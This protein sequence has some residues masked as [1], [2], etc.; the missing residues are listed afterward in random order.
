[1]NGVSTV[2][3][4]FPGNFAWGF[5]VGL[6]M[7]NL[8]LSTLQSLGFAILVYSGSAQMVAMPLMAQSTAISFVCLAAFLGCIRFIIYSAA[9]APNLNHLPLPLRLFVSA[10]SID[11][12]IGLYLARRANEQE[13][14]G[15]FAHRIAFLVGM[16]S[17]VWTAW[18]SGMVT[19]IFAAA[20]LPA[21][22][23]FSYLGIVA[24]IGIVVVMVQNRAGWACVLASA[25]VSLLTLHWPHQLGL[26][27][28]I[29]VGMAIGFGLNR[30][31]EVKDTNTRRTT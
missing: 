2:V 23:K 14:K 7:V 27:M 11:S 1:L 12:A 8:G 13:S 22:E 3:A 21:S 19:G 4:T 6:S 18:M 9:M 30:L 17:L 26:F 10:F 20:A 16:N 29:V 31:P 28:S 5:V 25:V 15:S 24:L